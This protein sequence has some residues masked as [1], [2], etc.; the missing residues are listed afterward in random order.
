MKLMTN[1][2]NR[3]L[4]S[5]F[6][7]MKVDALVLGNEEVSSRHGVS[8]ELD[9]ICELSKTM[10]CY[11]MLNELYLPD[12]LS[13]LKKWLD[14]LQSTNIKGILFQDFAVVQMVQEM[15]WD[16][17]LM[18]APDTLNTNSATLND[19]AHLGINE[20][21][22]AREIDLETMEIMASR[23]TVPLCVQ[24]HGVQYMAQSRRKLLSNYAHQTGIDLN[25]AAYLMKANQDER[26]SWIHEDRYGTH[27]QTQSEL[28]GLDFLLR[29]SEAGISWGYVD[30]QYMAP[31]YAIEIVNMYMDALKSIHNG[32]FTKDVHAY[33]ALL[34]GLGKGHVYD[35]G[36]FNDKTVYKIED[37]R[38]MENAKKGE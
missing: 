15:G 9:E 21:F 10:T 6:R 38:R 1:V 16:I 3:E 4:L 31:M 17:S 19:L 7:S 35:Q 14:G 37:V 8:F 24:V 12:E 18:Y 27:I 5:E 22:L 23:V 13:V 2:S 34:N 26:M 11:M 28:V 33:R 30:T 29:L 32:T 20:A 25:D 36:F